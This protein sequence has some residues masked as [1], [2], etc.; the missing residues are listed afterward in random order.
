MTYDAQGNITQR[1]DA[2]DETQTEN[3]GYDAISQLISFK[4]GT[5]VDKTYQFDLLGN[6]I[7]TVENG[8]TTNYTANNVNAYT[9]ITGGLSFTPQYDGNG[10][11]LNDDKHTYVY[12]LNNRM[13]SADNDAV[14]FKYDALGRRIAKNGI[15]Y[16]YIGDQMVEEYN[17]NTLA[18]SYLFG[19]NID[20]ALQMTRGDKTYYYHTNHLGST[21]S[22]TDAE[23]KLVE[24][25]AYDVYGVP[26]FSDA[27]GAE[28]ATS[29]VGNNILFT[30]REYDAELGIF[31]F[32][33]RSQHP[34]IGRFMQ[35]DPLMYVDGM[36]DYLYVNNMVTYY[37]D[38]S[39]EFI[40]IVVAIIAVAGA[41]YSGWQLGSAIRNFWADDCMPMADKWKDLGWAAA[42]AA[43]TFM[44]VSAGK[45]AFGAAGGRAFW[46][47]LGANGA[48][49][50]ENIAAQ[51]GLRTLETTGLGKWLTKK[52]PWKKGLNEYIWN[53][54]SEFYALTAGENTAA[55][56][57]N[58]VRPNS[59]WNKIESP[60]LKFMGN[61]P[62]KIFK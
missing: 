52:V 11:L 40:P 51:N 61:Y 48:K 23:G 38:P 43:L 5:A 25:V 10:N 1:K 12:D 34:Y 26:T 45:L 57:G 50:A 24:R 62:T 19:N 27:K 41:L 14:T 8:I 59:V 9:Y 56:L 35:H 32:R 54:A 4:R 37:N 29:S 49:V 55:I 2:I 16:Y 17:D 39:G 47:G 53:E 28:L 31:Y 13:V 30:G 36:N 6:R 44:P 7:K 20:E 3:Y 46:S 58:S 21:M 42:G 22:L 18:A 33:A 60:I 15:T